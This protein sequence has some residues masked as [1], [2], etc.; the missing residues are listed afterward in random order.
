[1]LTA[2]FN[3]LYL[4]LHVLLTVFIVMHRHTKANSLYV[5]TLF[6]INS[7]LIL[8]EVFFQNFYITFYKRFPL[9]LGVSSTGKVK[10]PFNIISTVMYRVF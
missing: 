1:M 7:I 4:S 2:S 3:L 5:K 8:I 9:R 6:S 10:S